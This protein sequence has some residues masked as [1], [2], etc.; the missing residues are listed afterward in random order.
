MEG[1]LTTKWILRGNGHTVG[2][3][4]PEDYLHQVLEITNIKQ[5]TKEGE[6]NNEKEEDEEE[7]PRN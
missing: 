6:V 5:I 1:L 4:S 2:E 7:I 3:T